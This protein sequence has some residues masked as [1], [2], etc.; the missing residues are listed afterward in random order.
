[1]G[2]RSLNQILTIILTDFRFANRF[3]LISILRVKTSSFALIPIQVIMG[4]RFSKPRIAIDGNSFLAEWNSAKHSMSCSG[5]TPCSTLKTFF[6]ASY[7]D[8]DQHDRVS[9]QILIG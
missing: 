7:P 4:F 3:V 2:S 9:F 6:D 8:Y 1:M 5:P